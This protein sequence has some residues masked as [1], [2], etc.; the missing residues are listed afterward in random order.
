MLHGHFHCGLGLEIELQGW[1]VELD[2]GEFD[3]HKEDDA[4]ASE[5]GEELLEHIA[6]GAFA[7]K[8]AHLSGFKVFGSGTL[9]GFDAF[10]PVGERSAARGRND[11]E[12][13]AP[14]A[15]IQ[16]HFRRDV[17]YPQGFFQ[18]ALYIKRAG[19]HQAGV[20]VPS[21]FGRAAGFEAERVDLAVVA[22]DDS[23]GCG[24]E[25]GEARAVGGVAAVEGGPSLRE[26]YRQGVG[27]D[28]GASGRRKEKQGGESQNGS[29]GAYPSKSHPPL[30]AVAHSA[31]KG[32]ESASEGIGKGIMASF[33]FHFLSFGQL[34]KYKYSGFFLLIINIF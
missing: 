8:G 34:S 24:D 15:V 2:V 20:D 31:A 5:L 7:H 4:E 21:S 25:G 26:V 27:I 13:F 1:I 28:L 9:E 3:V 11:V 33:C 14:G 17:F 23:A 30:Q 10:V 12:E 32:A 29:M 18:R 16:N 19:V 22:V 6:P